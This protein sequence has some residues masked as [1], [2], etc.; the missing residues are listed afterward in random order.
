MKSTLNPIS[1]DLAIAENLEKFTGRKWLIEE[2]DEWVNDPNGRRVYWILGR[3]GI[4]KTALAIKY[5]NIHD[6]SAFFLFQYDNSETIN[7]QRFVKTLAY[8]LSI[9]IS[10]YQDLLEKI[11]LDSKKDLDGPALL[12]ELIIIPFYQIGNLEHQVIIL[13]DGLDEIFQRHG[14]EN[15]PQEMVQTLRALYHRT[16]SMPFRFIFS[17][18]DSQAVQT[19]L[20]LDAV[21]PQFIDPDS[22]QNRDDIREYLRKELGNITGEVIP[23]ETLED[24]GVKSEG[25]FIYAS[26]FYKAVRDKIF[27]L[28][29]PSF[30]TGL[31]AMYLEYFEKQFH[32]IQKYEQKIIP[33]IQVICAAREALPAQIL[34]G[35]I[36]GEEVGMN[37]LRIQIDSLFSFENNAVRPF[38]SSIVEWISDEKKSGRYYVSLKKGHA[39]LSEYGF[40]HVMSGEIHEYFLR[41]LAYHLL[42][43][44]DEK[45]LSEL[46][47]NQEFFVRSYES[48]YQTLQRLWVILENETSLRME[49][50]YALPQGNRKTSS[51]VSKLQTFFFGRSDQ[52]NGSEFSNWYII[53]IGNLLQRMSKLTTAYDW[54]H[55]LEKKARDEKDIDSLQISLGN[56]ALILSARGDLDGAMKLHKEQERICRDLGNVDGLQASL[57][58]QALI[59][60]ARGDLDGAMKLHKEKERICRDLGNVDSLQISLGNQANILYVRGDLD[61]AMKL[62]KEEE[63]ICRNLGNVDSLQRSLGNQALILKARGDLDGAMKLHKEEE[64]ICRNLGN[65]DSL[66]RSLGNQAL[67]LKARG[68]LDGAM[69]LHKEKERICRDLGNVDSLQRSLGNQALILSARGDLDGAMKLHKEEERICR[70]LGNVDGLQA[71]LG[72][73]ALILK[74]RGDLDGA[75]KLHKEK[76]RICRELGNVDGLQASLGNQ[77]LILSARGDLDGA[78]KLHKEQERI[79]RELGNVDG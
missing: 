54:Y 35:I 13:L 29:Q 75:M 40:N 41:N 71:S 33:A 36:E 27:S 77:A 8:E 19:E 46:M 37:K 61:G 1:F 39:S 65:V 31:S 3:P 74:A 42:A 32:D 22:K 2:I 17:S 68:D 7:P 12:N 24:I 23:D 9:S 60:S 73:Q 25:F 28:D 79:C 21:K 63:R 4:G 34:T 47:V 11:D 62:H 66:Q 6:L 50:V 78:M 57:G 49:Q 38:H 76:E 16:E 14:M 20:Q 51:T 44:R 55:L 69:K 52:T 15:I 48:D 58:N 59:L 67:I 30:P 26:F 45:R 5:N 70:D 64:R 18:R 10:A 56:Q 53:D 43:I 72:N